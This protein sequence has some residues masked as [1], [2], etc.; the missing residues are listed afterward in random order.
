MDPAAGPLKTSM[1]DVG[2]LKVTV[3]RCDG[4]GSSCNAFALVEVG[5]SS[6]RTQ[7]IYKSAAPEWK[8]TFY[9]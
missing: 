9:L 8:K 1:K 5:N 2:R 3:E 4:L 7:T 6:V